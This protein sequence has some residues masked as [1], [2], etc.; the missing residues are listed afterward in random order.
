MSNPVTHKV[1]SGDTL[2]SLGKRY[3][4]TVAELKSINNLTSDTIKIGQIL[5]LTPFTHTVVSGDTLFSLAKKHN[6][7]VD[8]LK[9]LNGLKSD[10]IKVGQVLRLPEIYET[11]YFFKN[12]EGF[13]YKNFN[14]EIIFTTG[15]V[16]T[17]TTNNEGGTEKMNI[18]PEL[19]IKEVKIYSNKPSCCQKNHTSF[20]AREAEN[21]WFGHRGFK[22]FKKIVRDLILLDIPRK[23]TE[24]EILEL[25]KIFRESLPYDKIRV[26]EG[27]FIVGQYDNVAMSP[28]GHA[29]FPYLIYKDDFAEI[30][31]LDKDSWHLFVHEMY[32]IWHYYRTFNSLE[33]ING[34]LL[35]NSQD[36][37]EKSQ[38]TRFALQNQNL[39]IAY[40]YFHIINE[41]KHFSEFNMEQQAEM[42]A[43]Y[44]T[45][46][47]GQDLSQFSEDIQNVVRRL[48][49]LLQ[50]FIED[51]HNARND[52]LPKTND[53]N[54][55]VWNK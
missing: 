7:T 11:Q 50:D 14:Y 24:K 44:F 5:K 33:L 25:K 35:I 19:D 43:D 4:L 22:N 49:T 42:V 34:G 27:T 12:E 54:K 15:V 47:K 30:K 2:F 1:V 17:G 3:G 45:K 32:H 20:A 39:A 10:T 48:K 16:F 46:Y 53:I 6:T 8:T 38:D 29:Y 51:L 55:T 52:L 23:L 28:M 41:R 36:G 31:N 26:F 21:W 40:Q 9:S 37:Y 13:A 18:S